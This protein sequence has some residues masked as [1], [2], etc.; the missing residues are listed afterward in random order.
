M[1]NFFRKLSRYLSA[2]ANAKFDEKADPK[3]QIEQAI[4]EA[5][6]Q[7][8]ALTQQ[9]ASV[10]GNRRQLE[11]KLARQLDEV[12]RLQGSARQS[13]V[14][15]DQARAAGDAGKAAEYEQSAQAFATQLVSAESSIED[16]KALHDQA[17]QSSEAA[18]QAVEQN[19]MHLQQTLAERSKLLTQLEHA[20]MQEQMSKSMESMSSMAVPGD[21]PN[22]GEVRDKIEKRYAVAMG[23]QELA[24]TGV[25]ARMLEVQKA[26]MDTAALSRLDQIRASLGSG[27]TG[28]ESGPGAL[29][30]AE[31]PAIEQGPATADGGAA[32]TAQQQAS[33]ES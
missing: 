10:L 13:L 1:A 2:S 30:A 17:L 4:Q 25:E 6:R 32:S 22:L 15:A 31:N 24:S 26:T 11:M 5:Q 27:A 19:A 3:I 16:L 9:A 28:G 29:S 18:K 7:H 12:E 21:V 33:P 14:L 20:K 23:R 8:Q